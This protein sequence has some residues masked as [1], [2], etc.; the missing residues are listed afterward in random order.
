M[1]LVEDDEWAVV[2]SLLECAKD[3]LRRELLD[4]WLLD[5]NPACQDLLFRAGL[6]YDALRGGDGNAVVDE[7]LRRGDRPF[8]RARIGIETILAVEHEAK[9]RIRAGDDDP[10]GTMCHRRCN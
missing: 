1:I 4:S 6:A 8:V 2:D 10:V 9:E 3:L 5:V 7:V